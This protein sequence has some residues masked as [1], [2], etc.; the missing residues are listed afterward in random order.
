MIP[1]CL[2]KRF[3]SY[4]LNNNAKGTGFHR[5]Y[6]RLAWYQKNTYCEQLRTSSTA[7]NAGLA[8]PQWPPAPIAH[9]KAKVQMTMATMTTDMGNRTPFWWRAHLVFVE[10]MKN[11]VLPGVIHDALLS[12]LALI[13]KL[14]RLSC[15]GGGCERSRCQDHSDR[16]TL[17]GP[18][19]CCC[20]DVLKVG[21]IPVMI[22]VD[23]IYANSTN[24]DE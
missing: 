6:D 18:S 22:G 17:C 11:P 14:I 20:N 21:A 16:T 24:S 8:D 10:W 15:L 4:I 23:G 13:G 19:G 3:W 12:G 7:H 5:H 2:W 9:Q 1:L